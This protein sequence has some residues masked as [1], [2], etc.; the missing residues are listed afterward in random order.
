M[1]RDERWLGVLLHGGAYLLAYVALDYASYIK[2]YG[3]LGVSAW[4]PQ[5]GISLVL[6]YLGSR[7]YWP[8]ILFAQLI[9]DYV[10]RA[11]PLGLP[12]EIITSLI[13][14]LNSIL[15]AIILKQRSDFD[16]Q[17]RSIHD[18]VFFIATAGGITL[19]A[20]LSYTGSLSVGGALGRGDFG[21]VG[22]RVFVGNL[23]GI[24][25]IAPATFLV[26]MNRARPPFKSLWVWQF[27][28]ITIAMMIVFGYRE[29][30]AFQLFYLLF[31][32]LLWVA[33]TSGT[34]GAIFSLLFIQLALLF[35]A[36][37]RFGSDP[38]FT[39]LQVLMI[40][41]TITGML[42]G[43]AF[44]ERDATAARL[45]DQ[46]VGLNR[47]LRVRAAGEIAASI[48]HE[49]NQ[50]LAAIH[51]YASVTDALI[52]SGDLNA[53]RTTLDKL[54]KQ[55]ERAGNIIKS[56]R[57]L[58]H[59]G[60]ID[61]KKT[62]LNIMLHEFA[63][64]IAPELASKGAFLT[65]DVPS[66]LPLIS[67]DSVQLIQA[68]HNLVNNSA[69]AMASVG[70]N[71]SV[72]IKVHDIENGVCRM[73]VIDT[74]PG[75]PPGFNHNEVTP[76]FTTK[77]EGTGIGISIARTVA[78]AHGGRLVTKSGPMGATVELFLPCAE[79]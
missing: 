4:T 74:G 10:L 56:I 50:P 68:L 47:A 23:I 22:W 61:A 41:L 40:A 37:F 77:Q 29:A 20:A 75:F 26:V 45:R 55:S 35:G 9:T 60:K 11:G 13:T 46:Q 18:A 31:L 53:A 8:V 64:L 72:F 6:A 48:A 58:L 19:L 14:G 69:E 44:T 36:E 38:G 51:T 30:S 66:S 5:M 15:P 71:G 17:L 42:A 70:R 3:D 7:I 28:A 76:F 12:L 27:L 63:D 54:M 25:V 57:E 65:V 59:Q 43:A 33:L 34:A 62:D 21:F 32:P 24:L 16:P 73:S 2:P 52:S 39:P 1:Q 49:I 79:A 67:L 78:E